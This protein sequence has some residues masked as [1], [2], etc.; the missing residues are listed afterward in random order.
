MKYNSIIT[1]GEKK[2]SKA[3][4]FRS[5]SEGKQKNSLHRGTSQKKGEPRGGQR[6][7]KKRLRKEE[8]STRWGVTL[9]WLTERNEKT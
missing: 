7:Q 6:E 9:V 4:P 1:G 3:K 5:G 8:N 2:K